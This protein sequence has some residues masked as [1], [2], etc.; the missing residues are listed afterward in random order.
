LVRLGETAGEVGLIAAG[1]EGLARAA[2]AD[3]DPREAARLLGRARWLRATYDRPATAA[4]RSGAARAET[5]AR[6]AIGDQA[7]DDTARQ[8]AE[9]GL[10]VPS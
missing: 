9:V 2:V 10:G 4:E 8:G 5:A 1:L 3:N 6:A 7:Y